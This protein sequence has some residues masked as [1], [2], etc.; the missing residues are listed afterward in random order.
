VGVVYSNI[1][2]SPPMK[3]PATETYRLQEMKEVAATI[4]AATAPLLQDLFQ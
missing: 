4:I 2:Y 3:L 1:Y